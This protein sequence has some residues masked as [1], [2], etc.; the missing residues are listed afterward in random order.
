MKPEISVTNSFEDDSR[1]YRLKVPGLWFMTTR[2]PRFR[3][4]WW[5]LRML[6]TAPK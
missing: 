6:W 4:S 3:M 1:V 5:L 2:F